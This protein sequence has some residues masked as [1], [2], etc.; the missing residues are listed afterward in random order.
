MQKRIL[1]TSL[2]QIPTWLAVLKRL[3]DFGPSHRRPS[4]SLTGEVVLQGE[5]EEEGLQQAE[6]K[7]AERGTELTSGVRGVASEGDGEVP[8]E[9]AFPPADHC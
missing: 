5:E 2:L 3:R 1:H 4:P 9:E 6:E 8:T 7:G